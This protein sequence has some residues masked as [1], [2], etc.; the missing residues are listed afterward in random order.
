[1]NE[2]EIRELLNDLGTEAPKGFTAPPRLLHRARRRVVLMLA[3]SVAIAFVLVGGGIAGVQALRS[4]GVRPADQAPAQPSEDPFANVHGWI[5]YRRGGEALAV[6]PANPNNTIVLGFSALA[7][8]IAW[9]A[10]GTQL[11]LRGGMSRDGEFSGTENLDV[12][13]SDGALTAVRGAWHATWGSFSPDGSAIAYGIQGSY[14]DPYIIDANGGTPRSLGDPCGD[15]CGQPF[16]ESAAWSPD[17]S[18]IAWVDRCEDCSDHGNY[19]L[20]FVNPD[21]TGLQT[22]VATLPGGVGGGWSLVWSPDGSRLAFSDWGF[23]GNR[24]GQVFVINADG[25]GLTQI[26]KD[27][28]NRWPTWSPD[29]SRIA[30]VHDGALYTMASDGTDM[31]EVVGVHPDGAIAWNPVG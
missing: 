28:D 3:S 17:G 13:R 22:G 27:G 24:P 14:P 5:A 6:D 31:Q 8:P 23:F 21:G 4:A 2:T 19:V 30:F 25:S 26:T 18:R 9:S 12:L 7:D 15:R 29:G 1:M 11:L 10:D 16:A 20:S